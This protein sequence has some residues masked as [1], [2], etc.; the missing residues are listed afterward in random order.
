MPTYDYV[1]ASCGELVEVMHGVHARGP[2]ACDVCGGR[3]RKA[4]SLPAIVFKGSGW[5]KKDA[6]S[7]A[8]TKPKKDSKDGSEKSASEARAELA[9]ADSKA[10]KSDATD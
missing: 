7:S 5:A 8:A 1:C 6:R 10:T 4:M 2:E 3:M 9:V